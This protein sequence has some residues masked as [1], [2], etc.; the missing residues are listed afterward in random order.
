MNDHKLDNEI[1][2]KWIGT[3]CHY[4]EEKELCNFY[5]KMNR[6][7]RNNHSRVIW[8]FI[9]NAPCLEEFHLDKF[10]MWKENEQVVCVARPMS[11]WLGEVVIDNRCSTEKTLYDIIRYVEDNLSIKQENQNYIFLVVLNQEE[12]FNQLLQNAGY[13][14]LSLTTGTLQYNLQKEI[15]QVTL[16]NGFSIHPL[17][18]VFD[19]DQLSKLIWLGF[20]YEGDIPK[21]NDEVKLSIKHAWLNY[22]RDICSVVL[23]KNGEY[24]S[25]CGFWYDEMTQTAYLEPMVTLEKYRNMGLGKAA[26]INSLRILQKCGCKRAFVDPDEEPY[27]YYIKIGFERFEYARY[28]QKTF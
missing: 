24:A 19:F 25:F 23:D 21:I 15:N 10:K 4:P 2:E 28:Y 16:G 22:N 20:H 8:E 17:S 5:V 27:N 18:E 13:E 11:P 1:V 7:N 14:K 6:D 9:R 26:V 12:V 3:K